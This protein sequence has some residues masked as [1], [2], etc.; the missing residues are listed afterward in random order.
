MTAVL[1]LSVT[2]LD[3]LQRRVRA[4]AEER[5][6]VYRMVDAGGRVL[7][8]GKAKRLRTRLL[9]YF[10]AQYPDDKGARILQVT[11]D[12]AWDYV[13]SEFAA[14]L[15]ELRLIRRHRPPLNIRM[16]RTRQMAFVTVSGGAAP[17]LG[18]GSRAVGEDVRRY[19]PL[20][21]PARV[22]DGLRVIND[23]LGLRDC[24]ERMPMVYA[25]QQDLFA[26][27]RQAACLRHGLGTCAGP[28]AG[29][30]SERDYQARIDAAVAF[31]EG[32]GIRPLDVVVEEMTTRSDRG[33]FEGALRWRERFEH[34]EWLFAALNRARAAIELL[35]FVYRDPGVFGDERAYLIRR[36]AVR[37][38]FPWPETPIEREAFR[39][40]VAEELK[41][42]EPRSAPLAAETADETLLLLSWFRRFPEAL[43]R[44]EPLSSWAGSAD[45]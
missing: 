38:A 37:A 28:C 29:F 16:N 32:R 36:G 45:A 27:P 25:D 18:F 15:A 3:G 4:V 20:P 13:P 33:E 11:H 22:R 6:A 23:L 40:V 2:D 17:R 41:A 8:V 39:G 34:L 12:I 21:S 30:I 26:A 9:S 1:P 31:L 43:R 10:R 44:T 42:S 14:C 19:G 35:S 5:P 7:Y 24:P